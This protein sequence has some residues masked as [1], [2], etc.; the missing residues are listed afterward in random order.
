MRRAAY[1]VVAA[2]TVVVGAAAPVAAQ[3]T[4]SGVV[5]NVDV[6]RGV[7]ILRNG[8]AWHVGP[9]TIIVSHDQLGMTRPLALGQ[10]SSGSTVTL[11]NVQ[12]ESANA[13]PRMDTTPGSGGPR[14]GLH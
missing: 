10:V 13:S 1:A 11:R 5:A 2:L 8:T 7:V 3:E 12:P 9:D 4:P 14:P 6:A